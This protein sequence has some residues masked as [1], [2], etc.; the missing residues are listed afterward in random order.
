MIA[1]LRRAILG[2]LAA[3][4]LGLIAA[5]APVAAQQGWTG[6]NGVRYVTSQPTQYTY[7]PQ[8]APTVWQGY[9]PGSA[10]TGATYAPAYP[11]PAAAPVRTVAVPAQGWS[12]Y[13]PAGAWTGYAPGQAWTV[14]TPGV[15]ATPSVR[16]QSGVPGWGWS[17][18]GAY[19]E[20]STGRPTPMFRPW[21]KGAA[22]S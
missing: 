6:Y 9:A 8:A 22:G 17:R 13:N 20:P 2:T 12:G 11:A 10:W 14:Y 3:A 16:Q 19:R 21:L 18:N 15:S 7:V 4:G 5:P 1:S